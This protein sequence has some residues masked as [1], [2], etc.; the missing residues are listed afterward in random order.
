MTWIGPLEVSNSDDAGFGFKELIV[1]A[2]WVELRVMRA[3]LEQA[4]GR[5][6]E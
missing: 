2:G 4:L 6:A 3:S 1:K 5:V